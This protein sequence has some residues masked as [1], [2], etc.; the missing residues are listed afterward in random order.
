M[1]SVA[2]ETN[3][4]AHIFHEDLPAHD[5]PHA[6]LWDLEDKSDTH[7]EDDDAEAIPS[8]API[9]PGSDID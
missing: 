5:T 4:A 8:D 2:H 1:R 6:T 9:L 7:D 3:T